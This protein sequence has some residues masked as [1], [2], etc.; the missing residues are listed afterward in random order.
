MLTNLKQMAGEQ[1]LLASVLEGPKIQDA[2]DRELDR[3]AVLGR[4]RKLRRSDRWSISFPRR[5]A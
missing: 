1:L 3:R 5:V 2:V 4:L